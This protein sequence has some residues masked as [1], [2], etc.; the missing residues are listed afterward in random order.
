MELESES[1]DVGGSSFL[2]GPPPPVAERMSTQ[3]EGRLLWAV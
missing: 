3:P 1:I 2:S